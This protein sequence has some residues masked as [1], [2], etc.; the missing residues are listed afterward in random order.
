MTGYEHFNYHTIY[1]VD[2]YSGY[3]HLAIIRRCWAHTLRESEY[4]VKDNRQAHTFHQMLQ[5]LLP[6]TQNSW[7][8]GRTEEG[9]EGTY[10]SWSPGRGPW[11]ICSI[12]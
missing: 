5:L 1:V 7:I 9:E 12:P 10:G 11:R 8:R 3:G 6:T 4:A 2:G